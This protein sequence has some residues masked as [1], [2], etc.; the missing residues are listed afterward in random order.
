[1]ERELMAQLARITD[2]DPLMR[3]DAASRLG[4]IGDGDAVPAL[5]NALGDR[6][7]RVRAA[8]ADSLGKVADC[9]A[10]IPLCQLLS[11]SRAEVRRAAIISLEQIGD[12]EATAML[13]MALDEERDAE[14][15]RLL[16]RA[17]GRI[18]DRR[19]LHALR[20]LTGDKHWAVRREATASVQ[21]L[22]E[23]MAQTSG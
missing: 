6:E 13:L 21:R 17:L 23:R 14:T 11:E 8:A 9:C 22:I 1:M 5:L 16:V 10:T 15:R 20:Q 12:V 19:A 4:A 18:G 7:W 3:A 2:P